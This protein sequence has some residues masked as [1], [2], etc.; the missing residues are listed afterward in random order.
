MSQTL[1][2][3]LPDVVW[4][5]IRIKGQ[6]LELSPAEWVKQKLIASADGGETILGLSAVMESARKQAVEAASEKPGFFEEPGALP[7]DQT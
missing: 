1:S 5:A 4:L 6:Q 3:T 7:L 2:M